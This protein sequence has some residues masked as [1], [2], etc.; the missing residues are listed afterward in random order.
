[1][2][3]YAEDI[4]IIW[5]KVF[6]VL[7][8]YEELES[9][10]KF[11]IQKISSS[12]NKDGAIASMNGLLHICKRKEWVFNICTKG[13][14]NA[15]KILGEV[16][17]IVLKT[18]PFS[19]RLKVFILAQIPKRGK[20]YSGRQSIVPLLNLL[21]S[22]LRKQLI[23]IEKI[24]D[25]IGKSIVKQREELEIFIYEFERDK[26]IGNPLESKCFTEMEKFHQIELSFIDQIIKNF[27]SNKTRLYANVN[28]INVALNE[29][30]RF[31]RNKRLMWLQV[32]FQATPIVAGS[33]AVTGFIAPPLTPLVF[34]LS[35][36]VNF[37]PFIAIAL[38]EGT[39]EL[40]ERAK[41]RYFPKPAYGYAR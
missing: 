2:A 13:M 4:Q 20:K 6:Q 35:M 10:R 9:K 1:M 18:Q 26:I 21:Y 40:K 17:Q 14:V 24:F 7:R 15:M 30:A 32:K 3:N 31:T 5:K 41:K 12:S 11:Y 38:K 37:S 34:V 29:S 19:K 33:T 8:I 36:F 22:Q 23:F 16:E 25:Q 27:K 28:K 39:L